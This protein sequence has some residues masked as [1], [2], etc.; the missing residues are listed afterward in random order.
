MAFCHNFKPRFHEVD[1][2]GIIFFGRVFE[3]AHIAFEEVLFT[4][5][6]D[7]DQLFHTHSVGLPLVH[8]ESD[9]RKPM[10]QGD[11]LTVQTRVIR[12]GK[13]SLTFR[14][15]IV[16]EGGQ[17]RAVVRLT[18]AAIDL[19]TFSSIPLPEVIVERFDAHG[20]IEIDEE[21]AN[22]SSE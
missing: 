3:Y 5:F 1:R 19:K 11:D 15:D 4:V 18:H 7:W 10:R 2:A 21:F 16:D 8:A 6:G 14:H 17:V 22:H 12:V 9:F 13:G 20:L